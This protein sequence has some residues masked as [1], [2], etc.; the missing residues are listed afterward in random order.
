MGQRKEALRAPIEVGPHAA[1]TRWG[2]RAVPEPSEKH[3]LGEGRAISLLREPKRSGASGG[4]RGAVSPPAIRQAENSSKN[5]SD[6]LLTLQP[7][8]GRLPP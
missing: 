8:G 1:L 4:W 5:A 6:S 3:G 7:I 2:A